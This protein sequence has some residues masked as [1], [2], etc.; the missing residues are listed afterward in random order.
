METNN[1]CPRCGAGRLRAWDEL[2]DEEREVV[3]RLPP[4]ADYP[5]AE[6][7]ATHRWCSR[8]WYEDGSGSTT[9]A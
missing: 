1:N 6:R 5:L 2:N 8:C 9:L 4:S 7:Q 3:L